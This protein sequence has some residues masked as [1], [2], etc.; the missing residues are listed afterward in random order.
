MTREKFSSFKLHLEFR[1]PL[2]PKERG[3][4]RGNSGVYLQG[5][6]EV[7]VLDSFGLEGKDNECG[8]IY[9]I[10][11]P[12]VNACLPPLEWQTYD[13]TF[14]AP[15]FDANGEKQANAKL[16]VLHNGIAIHEN[17]EIP[18]MTGGALDSNI[19][20]SGP[21]MLQ[22]HSDPVQYRNIWLLPL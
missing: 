10:A 1:T 11:A 8:G 21:L 5:R 12:K 22:D 18:V 15:K 9:K 2:M 20:Q 19:D 7:Q 6:Y 17:L 14:Y 4:G 3:Q 16:T 13:I